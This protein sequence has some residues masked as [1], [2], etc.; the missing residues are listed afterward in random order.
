MA[1]RLIL[2]RHS[3]T[4]LNTN[5]IYSGQL[6]IPIISNIYP[7]IKPE[8]DLCISSTMIRCRQT[9]PLLNFENKP[10]IFDNRLIEAGYGEITGKLRGHIKFKRTF[11]NHPPYSPYYKSESIYESGIRAYDCIDY[12]RKIYK[13]NNIKNLLILSHKNTLSGLWHQLNLKECRHEEF[14]DFPSFHN[15]I[16]IYRTI[17]LP[18]K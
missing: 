10:I 11:F 5:N 17:K 16:P 6:D 4:Y 8:F 13:D 15:C 9:L 3:L 14:K 2:V 7:K 12:Y 1:I 18:Q